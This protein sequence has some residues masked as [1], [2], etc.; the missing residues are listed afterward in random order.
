MNFSVGNKTRVYILTGLPYAGKTTL[1]NE[2]VKQFGFSVASVDEEIDKHGFQVEQMTQNNWNLVYSQAYDKLKQL[3]NEGKTVILDNGNLKRSERDA[4]RQIAESK[5]SFYKLIYINTSKE[6]VFER[7]QRNLRTK[8][9]GHLADISTK[10]ALGIFQ[11]PTAD[12]K[13]IF[14][15]QD[16]NLDEW[17]KKNID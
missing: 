7:R 3:L 9:R 16:M 5:G 10:S 15:N 17:I 11:E 13:P 12:E 4:A 1:R 14:Y 2:L 6:V 8:D